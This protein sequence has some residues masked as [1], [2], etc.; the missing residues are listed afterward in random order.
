MMNQKKSFVIEVAA[1]FL[2]IMA[3]IWLP[4]RNPEGKVTIGWMLAGGVT[5]LLW[6]IIS[7]WW[8]GDSWDELGLVKET[9][10]FWLFIL[11]CVAGLFLIALIGNPGVFEKPKLWK[12]I[13]QKLGYP[14]WALIQQF[15]LQSYLTN[16]IG[17][18]VDGRWRA[19]FVAGA[20]FAVV[21]LPNPLLF[22]GTF[23]LGVGTA[24]FFLRCRNLYVI[25]F[26]HGILGTL[27]KYLLA[28]DWLNHGMRIGP[29]FLQ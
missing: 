27:V 17:K 2:L 25:A 9:K 26:A 10:S 7:I 5:I 23:V 16:R 15:L 21:H 3:V 1:F 13:A 6:L 24:Y 28:Q 8:R 18:C 14:T 4:P 29:G 19:A 12:N 20:L 11:V 22:T